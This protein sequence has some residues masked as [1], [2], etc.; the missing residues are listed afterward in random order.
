MAS[1]SA[2]RANDSLSA[3]QPWKLCTPVIEQMD[4]S[5]LLIIVS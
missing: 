5:T 4:S 3:T 2:W 1:A